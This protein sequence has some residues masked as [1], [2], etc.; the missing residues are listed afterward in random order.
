MEIHL[1][2]SYPNKLSKNLYFVQITTL[3]T[4]TFTYYR[5]KFPSIHQGCPCSLTKPSYI[6]SG[7]TT[8]SLIPT[9][10]VSQPPQQ[11]VAQNRKSKKWTFHH[12]TIYL[13]K[14]YLNRRCPLKEIS[15]QPFW[16]ATIYTCYVTKF[17]RYDTPIQ[18]KKSL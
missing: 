17:Q 15:F 9:P 14:G 4:M 18:S 12:T 16:V 5:H 10:M 2:A 6:C 8:T 11:T 13:L 3:V 1:K 7:V